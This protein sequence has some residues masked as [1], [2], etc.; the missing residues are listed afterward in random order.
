MVNPVSRRANETSGRSLDLHCHS[1]TRGTVDGIPNT[2]ALSTAVLVKPIALSTPVAITLTGASP[3]SGTVWKVP[4]RVE[5]P[6]MLHRQFATAATTAVD[7]A[8][9]RHMETAITLVEELSGPELLECPV[10]GRRG[11]PER[12]VDHVS[13]PPNQSLHSIDT[14]IL[15]WRDSISLI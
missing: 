10:C 9:R 5:Y 12:I 14:N 15:I 3:D 11:L 2:N 13:S 6:S 7:A 8:T 1:R 4:N